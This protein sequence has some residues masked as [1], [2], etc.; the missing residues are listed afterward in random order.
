MVSRP[1]LT[2]VFVNGKLLE[3]LATWA[4][5][6]M[7]HL[8]NLCANIPSLG[9]ITKLEK[10]ISQ[11]ASRMFTS[12]TKTSKL[13]N[14]VSF[15]HSKRY[16]WVTQ[17]VISH[18]SNKIQEVKWFKCL[19]SKVSHLYSAHWPW[20]DP[21]FPGSENYGKVTQFSKFFKMRT[22]LDRYIQVIRPYKIFKYKQGWDGGFC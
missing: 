2:C 4:S 14:S 20:D 8:K 18:W 15:C 6:M 9:C 16:L 11:N 7:Y 19:K 12:Q 10:K 5:Y 3:S 13:H 17:R 21:A 1:F 22:L